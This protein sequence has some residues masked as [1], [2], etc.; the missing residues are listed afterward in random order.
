MVKRIARNPLETPEVNHINVELRNGR[1]T[2]V[3]HTAM[4]L[5]LLSLQ[6]T[7][8]VQDDT[9]AEQDTLLRNAIGGIV[10]ASDALVKV[11]EIWEAEG[12]GQQ[13]DTLPPP[14]APPAPNP[15]V[16]KDAAPARVGLLD[17]LAGKG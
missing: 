8:W 5:R 1:I 10:N 16:V 7:E 3:E 15:H 12:K 9:S 14:P 11:Q 2:P 17:Q 13:P 6:V 4:L